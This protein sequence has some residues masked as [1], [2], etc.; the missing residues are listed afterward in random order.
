MA[1]Q[2]GNLEM[3]KYCFAHDCPYDIYQSCTKAAGS[4]DLDCLR[5][6]FDTLKPSRN[7]KRN[8]TIEAAKCG[9]LDILKYCIEEKKITDWL[10]DYTGYAVQQGKLTCLKYLVEEAKVPLDSLELVCIARFEE[11]HE[12]ENYLLEKGAP[13]PAEQ[14]YENLLRHVTALRR[15]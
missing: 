15:R 2:R 4:G 14:E 12:C 8:V 13:E 11:Q 1:G 10:L 7:T 5:F 6:L 9:H 3:L